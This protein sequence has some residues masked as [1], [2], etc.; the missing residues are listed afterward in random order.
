MEGESPNQATRAFLV[1]VV[2]DD[3]PEDDER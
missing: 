1:P 2:I 3:T